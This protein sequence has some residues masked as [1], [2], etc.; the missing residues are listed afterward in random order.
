MTLLQKKNESIYKTEQGS[1]QIMKLLQ[2]FVCGSSEFFKD[3]MMEQGLFPFY[4]N[5]RISID[6]GQGFLKVIENLFDLNK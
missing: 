2:V 6:G 1:L 4:T 3:I 5:V